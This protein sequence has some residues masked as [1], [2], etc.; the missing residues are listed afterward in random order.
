MNGEEDHTKISSVALDMPPRAL[1]FVLFWQFFR[2]MT[3]TGCFVAIAVILSAKAMAALGESV[4]VGL[5]SA[6]GVFLIIFIGINY[7]TTMKRY[8]GIF[9]SVVVEMLAVGLIT[10]AAHAFEEVHEMRCVIILR[11]QLTIPSVLLM[12][13]LTYYYILSSPP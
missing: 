6:M 2:E 13:S 12:Y 10:G 9:L 3:E 8:F 1:G 11:E 4:S 5:G 7:A